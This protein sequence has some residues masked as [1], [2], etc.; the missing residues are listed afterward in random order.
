MFVGNQAIK[1]DLG[2]GLV[3]SL[4]IVFQK[5]RD[6]RFD[7]LFRPG[8][9]LPDEAGKIVADLDKLL[10]SWL[11]TENPISILDL[12]GIPH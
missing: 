11:G 12:S 7:F 1:C 5:L 8:D 3:Q 10:E 9:Y 6:P 4:L 2:F